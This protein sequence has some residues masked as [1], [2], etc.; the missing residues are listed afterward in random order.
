[1]KITAAR[2]FPL[3]LIICFFTA[4]P[5][6]SQCI[7]DMS[8]AAGSFGFDGATSTLYIDNIQFMNENFTINWKL[9][10][11]NGNWDINGIGGGASGSGGALD[12]GSATAE[13]SGC[14]DM[15]IRNF[16]FIG[17]AFTACWS[18]DIVNTGTWILSGVGDQCSD[19]GGS[20]ASGQYRIV[21]TWGARPR[22]LDAHLRVP[23]DLEHSSYYFLYYGSRGR[24]EEFPFAHLENIVNSG[25]GPED[26][27]ITQAIQ[28]TYVYYV[29]QSTTDGSLTTSQGNVKL[30]RGDSLLGSWNVPS[31][32]DGRNWY[33]FD[34]NA[35]TGEVTPYNV[36][37]EHAPP[38]P[39]IQ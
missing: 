8:G 20:Q 35:I 33:V 2:L 17:Q 1:M 21:L 16:Q 18:L 23:P 38:A 14:L 13:F 26:I 27:I 28:G 19:G 25:Y 15:D 11:T 39:P 22:D 29:Y 4:A 7:L 30:Y 31:S 3:V 32:G 10:L 37:Q 6:G 24:L 36:I 9:N 34:L 12:F 5:V